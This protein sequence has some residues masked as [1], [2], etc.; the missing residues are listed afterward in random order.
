MSYQAFTGLIGNASLLLALGLMYDF[1]SEKALFKGR[2][3]AYFAGFLIG[4]LGIVVMMNPWR[5]SSDVVFDTRSILLSLTGLFFGFIPS[6]VA[7]VMT[8]IYRI[9]VSG[10]GVYAGLATIFTSSAIGLLWRYAAK[11]RLSSIS[12]SELYFFGIVVHIDMLFCMLLLP[13]EARSTFYSEISIPV[14]IIY[15]AAS[16]L[17]GTLL[18][19]QLE[20]AYQ[21]RIIKEEKEF[22]TVTLK[23]IGDAVIATDIKGKITLMNGVSEQLTEW[24]NDLAKGKHLD[25]VFN[26][27]NENSCEKCESPVDRVLKSGKIVEL[28]NHTV[29]ISRS[30]KRYIIEDSAAPIKNE[31]EETV[32]VVLVFRDMTEKNRMTE[33]IR[34][35]EKLES[36][37]IL[38]GG[39]AHDFNNLLSG[40]YGNIELAMAKNSSDD[41]QK[42]LQNAIDVFQRAKDLTG[43]LITFAKGGSPELRSYNIKNLVKKSASFALSGSKC[44]LDFEIEE[45]LW[46]CICDKE[47]IGNV[48]HNLILNASQASSDS[49][50]C[51]ISI[52]ARNLNVTEGSHLKL[53]KGKYVKVSVKDTGGGISK[54][55][56][57]KIFDPFFTTKE[58]G[59]GLGLPT[60]FSIMQKHNGSIEI[61]STSETG[62]LFSIYIPASA[63]ST[64]KETGLSGSDSSFN[65]I[66][67]K[68]LVMDDEIYVRDVLGSMLEQ[69]GFNVD[70]ACDGAEAILKIASVNEKKEKYFAVFFDLTVQGGMGGETAVAKLREFDKE[71]PVF[72]ASGYSDGE[73][74]VSPEKFG[75]NGSIRKPFNLIDLVKVLKKCL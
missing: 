64:E 4:L 74:I 23:S 26:I 59:S 72:A 55:N 58:N 2:K 56:V 19:R 35:T 66:G 37:G 45:N 62:T 70:K 17:L 10:L 13:S 69:L 18:S 22:L 12:M 43:Q 7:V 47:Q 28:A 71:T 30:G 57:S 31:A 21:K 36:L 51:R 32:G 44:L 73:I 1:V 27:I 29:L 50:V 60:C 11:N 24:K 53:A 48:I 54:E 38:A 41:V 63:D 67:K 25:E 8:S 42:Y 75:F 40:I 5:L 15:P 33:K 3:G 52:F 34:N 61:E 65:G 16:M 46:N 20:R 39:I 14:M 6:L 68:V 9:Y 49:K